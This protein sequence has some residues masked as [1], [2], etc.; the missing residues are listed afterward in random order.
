MSNEMSILK[1]GINHKKIVNCFNSVMTRISSNG[2]KIVSFSDIH[3]DIQSLIICLKD[4]ADVITGTLSFDELENELKSNIDINIDKFDRLCCIKSDGTIYDP[5]LGFKWKPECNKYVVLIGDLIDGKRV[6]NSYI[7]EHEYPQIEFKIYAFI[8][9]LIF[10]GADIYKILG[11]HE[12]MNIVQPDQTYLFDRDKT[13]PYMKINGKDEYRSDIFKMGQ[14]GYNAIFYRKCYV[15]LQI[16][17]VVF[18]HG[19]LVGENYTYYEV[20]NDVLNY[21]VSIDI[22][23][24]YG[25]RTLIDRIYKMWYSFIILS[26]YKCVYGKNVIKWTALYHNLKIN[27]DNIYPMVV[28]DVDQIIANN[29]DNPYFESHN[30]ILKEHLN[31]LNVNINIFNNIF[32][33]LKLNKLELILKLKPEFDRMKRYVFNA[34]LNIDDNE[35]WK[36]YYGITNTCEDPILC[37][38][39]TDH[40]DSYNKYMPKY[41]DSP[42]ISAE[43]V[44]IGHCAQNIYTYTIKNNTSYNTVIQDNNG[45]IEKLVQP[46][47]TS[48]SYYKTKNDNLI[49][50]ITMDCKCNFRPN[51][52]KL[53]RVDV[54]SSRG[55]D[56][57]SKDH[58]KALFEEI[59]FLNFFESD[60]KGFNFCTMLEDNQPF[61]LTEPINKNNSQNLIRFSPLTDITSNENENNNESEC[62]SVLSDESDNEASTLELTKKSLIED[63]LKIFISRIPQVLEIHGNKT[64]IIRS[65]LK[66]IYINQHRSVMKELAKNHHIAK[67]IN[68]GGYNLNDFC[69]GNSVNW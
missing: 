54:G 33:A 23:K 41:T 5:A 40:L 11:N 64:V 32:G 50:G 7:C 3:S 48:H 24:N 12:V 37:Q 59:D 53:Y 22:K 27:V 6:N 60:F 34:H 30:N 21:D 52:H 10:Q 2:K 35:L 29:M 49:F 63:F 9:A 4:C 44:V 14:V 17:D 68:E 26:I 1:S 42:N 39:V 46:S 55:F 15:L 51:F 58:Y 18:V 36:R 8:N 61:A 57:F 56:V 47:K 62:E 31:A 65:T 19:Q 25:K 67:V 69:V 66:N 16:D 20:L 28:N 43:R 38:T 13:L 45:M